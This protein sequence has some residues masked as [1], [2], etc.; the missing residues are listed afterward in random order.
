MTEPMAARGSTPKRQRI[1]RSAASDCVGLAL[2]YVALTALPG[3]PRPVA[4]Q[5]P[6]DAPPAGYAA[7]EVER[8]RSCVATL[9]DLDRLDAELDPLAQRSRRF[10]GIAEAIAI[11]D[12]SIVTWLNPLEPTES[13]VRDWFVTD[14]VLAERFVSGGDPAVQEARQQGRD[15]IKTAIS[16]A[17]ASVQAEADAVL[18]DN[19]DLMGRGASCDGA[20]FVRPVVVDVCGT[21]DSALCNAARQP[22]AEGVPFR[23]VDAADEVWDVQELRPWTS[24]GPIR[25]GAAGLEGARTLGYAR[26]GNVVLTA[27]VAAL[28]REGATVTAAERVRWEQ[29]NQALGLALDH[30]EVVFT[31]ALALRATLPQP[32]AGEERYLVHFDDP[33][34]PEVLWTGQAGTGAPLET[35]LPLQPGQV[36]RLRA[37][38]RIALTAVRGRGNDPVFSI[39]LSEIGQAA[40]VQ[41]LL[42]YLGTTFPADVLRLLPPAG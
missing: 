1:R 40:S 3:A 12:R 37:G 24:P 5:V 22:A 14:S 9:A 26:V 7:F 2:G 25:F 17:L 16:D 15:V 32:I 18:A 4:G 21:D 41:A 34:A 27:A 28:L 29:T 42:T 20:I 31:P 33:S 39:P 6:V 10:L 36:L 8:S 13:A 23:F 30:P 19:E 11:E 38:D 35:S